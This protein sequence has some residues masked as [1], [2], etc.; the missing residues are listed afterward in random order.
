MARKIALRVE[1]L[2]VRALLSNV[3]YSLTTDKSAYAVG[4]PVQFTFTETNISNQTIS[5]NDGPSIDGF[6]VTLDGNTIWQS[7]SGINPLF[8]QAHTLKPGQ[9]LTET[10]T[11]NGDTTADPSIAATGSFAVTNQLA[12]TSASGTFQI[13]SPVNYSVATNQPTYQLGQPVQLTL[14]ATNPSDQPVAVNLNAAS[15][16]VTQGGNP[17]WASSASASSQTTGSDTLAPGQTITQSATW[18]G[19]TSWLGQAI[20]HWGTFAVSSPGAPAGATASFQITSPLTSTLTTDKATYAANQPV[21]MTFQQTNSSDQPVTYLTGSDGFVVQQNGTTV[22]TSTAPAVTATSL[23]PG[24]STT[25]TATWNGTPAGGTANNPASGSFVVSTTGA[26]QGPTASFTISPT[27]TPTPT[28]TATP[29]PTPT[30]TPTPTATPTPTTTPTPTPTPTTTPTPTP[31]PTATPTP[32]PTTTTTPTPTPTATPTPT[33][34]ATTTPAPTPTPPPPTTTP[35]PTP[36]PTPVPTPTPTPSSTTT[37]TPTATPTPTISVNQ[38]QASPPIG[39]ALPTD[40][41]SYRHG[42]PVR[43]TLVLQNVSNSAVSLTPNANTDGITVTHGS[44][45]VWRSSR[46]APNA[47][48]SQTIQP[49]AIAKFNA[50]WNGR[51]NQR[52][53]KRLGSGTFTM[54]V[55]QGGYSASATF[56]VVG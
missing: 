54:Q 6:N 48:T 2:E 15:F 29:T 42:Q 47:G 41:Q 22:Y 19:T 28:P 51:P 5:V 18:D 13:A 4:Q 33:P 27:P 23:K 9:S 21:V 38:A 55:T 30:T 46:I 52:G 40:R 26:P 39:T 20:D 43:A 32:T 16:T 25:Q 45:V 35:A 50:V 44:T 36:T 7:N 56:R 10:A 24:Q 12:P 3:A 31:T 34:T 17:V 11:W 37:S 53:V 49:R 8:I 14:T 1:R